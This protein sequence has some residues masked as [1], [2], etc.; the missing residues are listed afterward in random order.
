MDNMTSKEAKDFIDKNEGMLR[1]FP[2]FKPQM[3]K[4]V[5]AKS[6]AETA[7]KASA[8]KARAAEQRLTTQT[9]A[10]KRRVEATQEE[11]RKY[12]GLQQNILNAPP[13]KETQVAEQF[14]DTLYKD[15]KIDKSEYS[16]LLEQIRNVQRAAKS[17]REAKQQLHTLLVRLGWGLGG[18]GAAGTL[19]YV[20]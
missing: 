12:E 18:V 20:F 4:I 5:Q 7:P 11:R 2:E 15:K 19:G 9:G 17:Q 14:V 13:G 1:V 3:E 8:E 10:A 16:A 6:V